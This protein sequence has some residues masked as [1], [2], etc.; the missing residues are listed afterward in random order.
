M[1][2]ILIF[3]LIALFSII[4]CHEN[5]VSMVDPE[6]SEN[7]TFI[8]NIPRWHGLYDWYYQD[9]N[10]FAIFPVFLDP[11]YGYRIQKSIDEGSSWNDFL[12]IN[13]DSVPVNDT[14]INVHVQNFT[15]A[16]NGDYFFL[17]NGYL[18]KS[19]DKG[20]SWIRMNS[21]GEYITDMNKLEQHYLYNLYK[22]N[23]G[24]LFARDELYGF[25]NSSNNGESWKFNTVDKPNFYFNTFEDKL[26][27]L[28]DN[29]FNISYNNGESWEKALVN[30]TEIYYN[31]EFP[32]FSM[33]RG[34][35]NILYFSVSDSWSD[36]SYILTSNDNGKSWNSKKIES[37][38][39]R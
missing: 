18:F 36:Y 23:I 31:V 34:K 16:N 6:I 4:G 12:I 1:K 13:P 30:N 11:N 8:P 27:L 19:T 28:N 21:P 25:F 10:L 22:D 26:I 5:T 15:I 20:K 24:N 37:V 33:V 35:N 9:E 17:G 2:V 32:M 39:I 7:F 38:N 14:S 29:N 3:L